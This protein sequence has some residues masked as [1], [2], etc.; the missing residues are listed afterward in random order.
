MYQNL[1]NVIVVALC[2]ALACVVSYRKGVMDGKEDIINLF[3]SLEETVQELAEEE[4]A[5]Q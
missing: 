1:F 3:E 2:F 5:K 4:E